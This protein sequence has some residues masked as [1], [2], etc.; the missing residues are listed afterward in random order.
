MNSILP[1]PELHEIVDNQKFQSI[2]EN[3]PTLLSKGVTLPSTRG[4]NIDQQDL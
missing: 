2:Y 3:E 4:A 1:L